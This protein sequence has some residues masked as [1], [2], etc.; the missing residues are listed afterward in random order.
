MKVYRI[1]VHNSR[2]VPGESAQLTHPVFSLANATIS[3]PAFLVFYTC[4]TRSFP[5]QLAIGDCWLALIDL[6]IG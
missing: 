1:G 3:A 4:K 2:F 5:L 6:L